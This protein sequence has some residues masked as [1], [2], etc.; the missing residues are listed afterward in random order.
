MIPDDRRVALVTGG[1]S[2]IGEAIARKLALD[3]HLVCIVGR[4][5]ELIRAVADSI[6]GRAFQA[7]VT[8]ESEVEAVMRYCRDACSRLD[9]L[10][11]AAGTGGSRTSLRE[12]DIADWDRTIATN[13]RSVA[14]CI[15]HAIP[16]L[17][18]TRGRIVNIGSRDGLSG[19]RASRS[20]YVA[21]KFALTG[22]TEALAQE[23]GVAGICVN[24]VCPGAV[25]TDLFMASA[26]REAEK[27]GVD[28]ETFIRA[29][30]AEPAALK[31]M[32]SLD[33]VANA[34]SFLASG[35]ATGITGIHLKVDCGRPV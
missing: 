21:S 4:R 35:A 19:T 6:G 29:R 14:L 25:R 22:L 26:A 16:L 31:R 7:D 24:D 27:S 18:T 32:V 8:I 15:K 13:L 5:P 9:V 3:G 34:V 30:F 28:V 33:D 17:E 20:D 23:L 2:G 10:V 12:M 1:G 11:N